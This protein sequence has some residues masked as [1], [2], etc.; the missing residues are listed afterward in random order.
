MSNACNIFTL[1][2]NKDFLLFLL[3][4]DLIFIHVAKSIWGVPTPPFVCLKKEERSKNMSIRIYNYSY[5][6]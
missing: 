2:P 5:G 1:D 4:R 3:C 6:K